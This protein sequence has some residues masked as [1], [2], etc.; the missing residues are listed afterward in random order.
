MDALKSWGLAVCFAALAAGIAAIITPSGKM[1]KMFKLTISLFFLCCILVPLFSL[2]N[3]IPK[4]IKLSSESSA[5]NTKLNSAV[6]KQAEN[7]S[8]ERLRSMV[9]DCCGEVGVTPLK[10]EVK[11]I[12]NKDGSMNAETAEVTLKAEDFGK[13]GVISDAVKQKTGLKV[14]FLEGEKQ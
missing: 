1:E 8:S 2:G 12:T 3:I 11:I 10:A 4:D 6:T 14:K 7:I 5:G 9:I 13:I